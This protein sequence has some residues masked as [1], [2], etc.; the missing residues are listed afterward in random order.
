M[1]WACTAKWSRAVCHPLGA[2]AQGS[3]FNPW[4]TPPPHFPEAASSIGGHCSPPGLCLRSG[5][6]EMWRRTWVGARAL[7]P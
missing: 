3:V 6:S 5:G 4:E 1:S 2:S 7:Q